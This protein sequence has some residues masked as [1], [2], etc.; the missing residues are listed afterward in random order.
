MNIQSINIGGKEIRAIIIDVRNKDEFAQGHI[1]GSTN[2][3]LQTLVGDIDKLKE[4][5]STMRSSEQEIKVVVCCASGG[6]SSFALQLLQNAG[7]ANIENAGA[8]DTISCA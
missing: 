7:I 6:R 1:L 8:W 5:I 2:L 3:P 4:E